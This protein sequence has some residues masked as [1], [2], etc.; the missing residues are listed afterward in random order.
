[1]SESGTKYRGET[2]WSIDDIRD[3]VLERAQ[4]A[5]SPE[6]ELRAISTAVG[7]DKARHFPLRIGRPMVPPVASASPLLSLA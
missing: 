5:M 7:V 6:P 1:V 2:S 3:H 4:V